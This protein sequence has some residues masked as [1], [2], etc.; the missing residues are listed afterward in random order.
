MTYTTDS[1]YENFLDVTK[2]RVQL[3]S[4]PLNGIG[5]IKKEMG[6][7]IKEQGLYVKLHDW[8]FDSTCSQRGSLSWII[9]FL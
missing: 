4:T 9:T 7:I 1:A 3:S 5:Y 8:H 6:L 2:S